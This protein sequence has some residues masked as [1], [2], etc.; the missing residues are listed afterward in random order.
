MDKVLDARLCGLDVH[1]VEEAD[2]TVNNEK[3]PLGSVVV[4]A[5]VR[6]TLNPP[7]RWSGSMYK[8]E[9]VWSF[10]S[11]ISGHQDMN[12]KIVMKNNYMDET[13]AWYRAK[14]EEDRLNA[15]KNGTR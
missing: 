12:W 15:P 4:T 6:Y 13:E 8:P 14:S 10:Q 2:E 5:H 11:C 9:L 3:F 1:V 7:P